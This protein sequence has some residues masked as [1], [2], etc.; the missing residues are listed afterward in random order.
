[1]TVCAF[2]ISPAGASDKKT[3]KI[4]L[5]MKALTNPFFLKMKTVAHQ[6]YPCLKNQVFPLGMSYAVLTHGNPL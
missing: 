1:M 6:A 3:D 5:V 2:I 4:A